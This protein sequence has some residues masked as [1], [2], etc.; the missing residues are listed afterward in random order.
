[1]WSGKRA[2]RAVADDVPLRVLAVSSAFSAPQTIAA[3]AALAGRAG[4]LTIV[5]YARPPLGALA[6]TFHPDG[7]AL[8]R[9]LERRV[10]ALLREAVSLVPDDCPVTVRHGERCPRRALAGALTEQAVDLAVVDAPR[11]ARW[12]RRRGVPH[13]ALP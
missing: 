10:P 8:W 2:P 4:R 13:V 6:A 12:L 3:A 9:D 11:W 1:M 7:L 5:T